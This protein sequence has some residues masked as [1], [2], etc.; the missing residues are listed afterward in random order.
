MWVASWFASSE[1]DPKIPPSPKVMECC[2]S[3]CP[4]LSR[5]GRCLGVVSTVCFRHFFASLILS[6][7]QP[8]SVLL[9]IVHP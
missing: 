4:H 3:S 2:L 7:H 5:V 9:L 6:N 8:V 1:C